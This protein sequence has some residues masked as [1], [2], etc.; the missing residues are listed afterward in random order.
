MTDARPPHLAARDA[1]H[2]T[3]NS[4]PGRYANRIGG[5]RF[6]I[7]GKTYRTQ[8]NDGTNTLHSGTNNW[9]Y[10]TW[11]ISAYANDSITFSLVD[12][13]GASTGMPGKVEANVT[14]SV[15][16][17]KWNTKMMAVSP[18]AKTRKAPHPRRPLIL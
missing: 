9:S 12:P 10:R 8:A 11:T 4:I 16:K 1:S 13:A 17:G 18:E 5:A 2:P 7:D 3:Y 14:Y 15:T 6:T